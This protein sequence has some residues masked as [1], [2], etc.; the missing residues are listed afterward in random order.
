MATKEELFVSVSPQVYRLAK[1]NV[2]MSQADLLSTL[3]RLHHLRVLA[4]QKRDLKIRLHKLFE[5]VSNEIDSLR[6]KM[7]T[8]KLPK[9]IHKEEAP[10]KIK[11]S[12]ARR[13]DIEEE[14]KLIQ[15]KLRE[16]NG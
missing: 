5:S 11:E 16:L 13:D 1:S 2:L 12:F 3:K 10:R 7:P 15:E 9:T 8:S 4:R 14:L 6:D